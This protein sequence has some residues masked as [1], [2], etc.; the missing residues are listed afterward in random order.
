MPSSRERADG[1]VV[2]LVFGY[3]LSRVGRFYDLARQ[4]GFCASRGLQLPYG[5]PRR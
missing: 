4:I 5:A 1:A 3:Q 2:I